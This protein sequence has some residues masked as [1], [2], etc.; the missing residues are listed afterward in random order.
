MF[1]FRGGGRR[2]HSHSSGQETTSLR[3]A[4][5]RASP[6]PP[7]PQAI[8]CLAQSNTWSRQTIRGRST[9]HCAHSP[10][11][12]D[13]MSRQQITPSCRVQC[14]LATPCSSI[15]VRR[16]GGTYSI[17]L[18]GR[19][20]SEAKLDLLSDPKDGSYSLTWKMETYSSETSFF[21]NCKTLQRRE[22]TAIFIGTSVRTSNRTWSHVWQFTDV[23]KERT[24]SVFSVEERT[25]QVTRIVKAFTACFL[26]VAW[27]IYSSTVKIEAVRL[28]TSIA[29]HGVTS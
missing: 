29:L 19:R 25:K 24:A 9:C 6:I 15:N 5:R 2:L 13:T 1:Y 16:F 26:L 28:W 27:L 20:L 23:S 22:K 3:T 8:V 17:H 18:H 11:R 14:G 10:R 12:E 21:P 4:S 7:P